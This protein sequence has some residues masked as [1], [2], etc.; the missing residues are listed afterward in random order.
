MSS[1]RN[2]SR[3]GSWETQPCRIDISGWEKRVK[4]VQ[5]ATAKVCSEVVDFGLDRLFN[6]TIE[7][8]TAPGTPYRENYYVEIDG[9]KRKRTRS[10]RGPLTNAGKLPIPIVTGQL[11]RSIK[12]IRFNTIFGAVWSDPRIAKHNVYVH[13]GTR[14]MAPRPFLQAAVDIERPIILEYMKKRILSEI[15]RVGGQMEFKFE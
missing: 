13:F 14:Y 10:K 6:R 7:H 11:R 12:S 15:Q 1:N 2:I 9:E 4:D 8:V 5:R 3:H